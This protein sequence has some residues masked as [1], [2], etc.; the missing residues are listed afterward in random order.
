MTQLSLKKGLVAYG[1]EGARAV[2]SELKQLHDKSVMTPRAANLLTR[3]EK[4]RALQYLMYLKKKRC[5]RIKGRGCADGQ[6][7]RVYKSKEES[8][9]PTVAIESL[10]LTAIIDA[11]ERR[12][13]A[14]CDIP[15][16]FLHS[17]ID[18]VLHMRIDGPMAKLLVSIDPDLYEPYLTEENGK[19][20][21]YV[22]LEKALYGT[23]QAAL[24]FW[25]NLSGFL[26]EQG[27]ELNPYD[28]FVANKSINGT[29]CTIVWHV[30]ISRF[31]TWTH[32]LSWM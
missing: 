28:E 4:C 16:A 26:M 24:L 5:G 32:K 19:P 25:R 3:E 14:T 8:S 7:Q 17:D 21:I 2:T 23:L 6:K 27:F 9:S 10:F 20:V 1:E 31:C 29:Q 15:G 13:V 30:T 11:K 22:K 12:D 18:E